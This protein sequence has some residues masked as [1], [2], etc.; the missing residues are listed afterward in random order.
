MK[1][2]INEIIQELLKIDGQEKILGDI[3]KN[4]IKEI[5]DAVNNNKY[6]DE[7]ENIL[8]NLEKIDLFTVTP[9][10]VNMMVE[11]TEFPPALTK[12]TD[13]STSDPDNDGNINDRMLGHEISLLSKIG[14]N[15]ND[16][17]NP[18][19]TD[20]IDA[21]LKVI[22]DKSNY[23]NLLLTCLKML[24]KF[25]DN[26]EIFEMY[27]KD[28]LDEAFIDKLN[29]IQENYLDDMPV[30]KEI[31]NILCKLCLK[32]ERLAKHISNYH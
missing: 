30:T 13:L 25:I 29:T 20:I 32:S 26:P 5:I 22:N 11:E 10:L 27:L 12:L 23:R 8:T 19:L 14:E 31:N 21:I 28:R 9:N 15:I 3:I 17:Y 1:R 18:I 7:K 2:E 16:P 4:C 24:S 6:N